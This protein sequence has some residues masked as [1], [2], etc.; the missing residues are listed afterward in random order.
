MGR[1]REPGAVQ[2]AKG[3]PGKRRK[4]GA[5]AVEEVAAA[6]R[7]ID[8]PRT[9]NRDERRVWDKIA[10]ELLRVNLVRA[11]D[12][13]ALARYC[14]NLEVWWKWSRKIRKEGSTY[15]SESKHGRMK[16][17]HPLF[18]ATMRLEQAL[19]QIEDRFGLTP[20]ARQR[21]LLQMAGQVP[22][23]PK[24]L[25]GGPNGENPDEAP[26]PDAPGPLGILNAGDRV[27]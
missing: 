6:P 11:T 10:P 9:L 25:F 24:G 13:E 8:P 15:E 1:R 17:L 7:K 14:Y 26:P 12:F 22:S 4:T 19:V 5:P 21:L 18:H 16:R 2:A 23:D 27:H 3:H 20:A